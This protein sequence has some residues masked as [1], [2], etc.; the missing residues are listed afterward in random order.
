MLTIYFGAVSVD[1]FSWQLVLPRA[2]LNWPWFA[3]LWKIRLVGSAV[4]NLTPVV[5]LA[6]CLLLVLAL[7]PAS[8]LVGTVVVAG[9][10]AA[11]LLQAFGARRPGERGSG[12]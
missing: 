3:A 5:G 2:R 12:P 9:G 11:Y 10:V 7:P 1:T 4:N 6:G 8:V